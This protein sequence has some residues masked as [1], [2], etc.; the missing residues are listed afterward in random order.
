MPRAGNAAPPVPASARR[1]RVAFWLL[2]AT[3]LGWGGVGLSLAIDF[4]SLFTLPALVRLPLAAMTLASAPL[5]ALLVFDAAR[6]WRDP[7]HGGRRRF[8]ATLVA[9]AAIGTAALLYGLQLW[10]FTPTW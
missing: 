6:R 5:A 1:A 2:F 4:G 8:G 3:L 9:A 7:I 10:R